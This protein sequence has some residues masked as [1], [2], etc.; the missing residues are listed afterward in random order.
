MPQVLYADLRRDRRAPV[1]AL[2]K[3]LLVTERE[4]E[5]VPESGNAVDTA[6]RLRRFVGERIARQ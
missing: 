4:H 6:T 2:R 5:L 3:V 1:P